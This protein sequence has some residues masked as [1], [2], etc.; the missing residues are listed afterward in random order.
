MLFLK[1]IDPRYEYSKVHIFVQIIYI[2]YE[3]LVSY[4]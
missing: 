2:K 4:Y 3:Y 1:I